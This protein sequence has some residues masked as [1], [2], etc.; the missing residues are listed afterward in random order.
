[1]ES[2]SKK[3][4]LLGASG[5]IGSQAIDIIKEARGRFKLTAFSVGKN[6]ERAKELLNSFTNVEEVYIQSK[7]SA[8]KLKEEF[9]NVI[10][11][12]GKRGLAK[13]TR[14][15][16]YDMCVDALV[17]FAG[18]EPAVIALRKKKILCL[19]N[20]EALVAGGTLI[21]KILKRGKAKLYPI[22]SE[23]VALAKCLAK[24]NKE[25]VK[26][27][28]ITASGGALRNVP[29]ENLKDV[30]AEDALKHP[31]WKMGNKITID[32]ATMMNKGFEI[33]EA[34]YLYG[35]SLDQIFVQMHDESLV[36]SAVELKDGT[37]VLDYGQPDMHNP[38]RW[39]MYEGNVEY[40]VLKVKSFEELKDC[41]FRDYDPN[42][43]PCTELA[44]DALKA[45]SSKMIALNASNE[46]LVNRYLK[47]EIGFLDIASNVERIVNK[48][49]LVKKPSLLKIK[50]IDKKARKDA[51]KWQKSC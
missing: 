50:L 12:S 40:E 45:G 31:T 20:K 14:Y 10:V 15:S 51:E 41:H 42:R 38:I 6:Y 17:G 44:K 37:I 16:D 1:M 4:L 9:H 22:D 19:A 35:Y 47:G 33:I 11:Y 7:R 32:C 49:R 46:V 3:V 43:Y 39:A 21:N 18:L 28:I 24:V 8:E 27:L 29:I 30:K 26:R 13:L 36:H 25:D 48:T 34:Y 23:H 5:S 2:E